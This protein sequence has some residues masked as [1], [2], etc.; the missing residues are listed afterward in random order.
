[1]L[2][3]INSWS[4]AV[5]LEACLRTCRETNGMSLEPSDHEQE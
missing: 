1:M 4:T 5:W 3:A 2:T